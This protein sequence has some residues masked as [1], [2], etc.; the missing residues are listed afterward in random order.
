MAALA[1][2][3]PSVF[4]DGAIGGMVNVIPKKP[5]RGSIQSEVQ[6]SLGS[7]GKC[8]VAFVSGG[9]ISGKLQ[10]APDAK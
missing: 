7:K 9:V 5:T 8:A 2:F 6:A 4:G 10:L 1:L 3:G